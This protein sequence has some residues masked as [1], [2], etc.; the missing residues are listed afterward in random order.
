MELTTKHT[1]PNSSSQPDS[2]NRAAQPAKEKSRS[3]RVIAWITKT[4][5]IK[6]HSMTVMFPPTA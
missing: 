1:L 4:I 6:G 5:L 3:D 2:N